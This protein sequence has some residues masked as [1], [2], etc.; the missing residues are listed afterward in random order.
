[1]QHLKSENLFLTAII[2]IPTAPSTSQSSR[3]QTCVIAVC[4]ELDSSI[5]PT[6][7]YLLKSKGANLRLRIVYCVSDGSPWC[8]NP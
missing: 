3:Y 7:K 5:S 6:A 8:R 2:A 4:P 1:M